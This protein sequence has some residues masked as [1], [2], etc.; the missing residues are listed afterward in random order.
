MGKD[1]YYWTSIL[2][3]I[4]KKGLENRDVIGKDGYNET[5]YLGHLERIIDNKHDKC[6]SYD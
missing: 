2:L 5:H 4:S 3:G 6:R 1:L